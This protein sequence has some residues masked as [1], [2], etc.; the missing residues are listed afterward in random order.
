MRYFDGL[1]WTNDFH[2]PGRLPEIGRWLN[3]TFSVFA[4]YWRQ[5]AALA[6]GT[7]LVSGLVVWLGIRA[8]LRDVAVQNE[9]FVGAGGGTLSGLVV[10]ALVALAL[11]GYTWLVLAR[12]LHRAH[13]QAAPTIGDA[14]VHGLQRLPKYL[15]VT[16]GLA[17]GATCLAVI[18]AFLTAAVPL[19]GVLAVL[20]FIVGAVWAVVK[21]TFYSIAVAIAP[22]GTSVLQA[23]AEV[24]RGR[25]WP[26]CGRV[27]LVLVGMAIAA[28]IVSLGLGDYGQ[29]IDAEML[30]EVVR[31]EGEDV[32]LSDFRVVDL[33]PSPSG[34]VAVLIVNSIVQGA[35]TLITTSA[36]VRLYLDAGAPAD[37]LVVPSAAA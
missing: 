7:A 29:M 34:F 30:S 23:S 28:Q 12:F 11:Q 36:L 21:L 32:F 26:V 37:E 24:S 5:A 18:V 35:S 10:L 15:V 1:A 4:R 25:F 13:Y 17:I 2:E 27:V 20:A 22:P 3:A 16:L 33:F 19:L 9:T 6:F 8:L 14:L 31:V